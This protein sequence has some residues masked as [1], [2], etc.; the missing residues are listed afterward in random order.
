MAF[1]K[2]AVKKG[3]HA[4]EKAGSLVGPHLPKCGTLRHGPSIGAEPTFDRP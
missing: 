1:G 2:K 4:R 3:K